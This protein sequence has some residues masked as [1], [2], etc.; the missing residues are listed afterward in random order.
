MT[1][2][3][4]AAAEVRT[5]AERRAYDCAPV[6]G[7][8]RRRSAVVPPTSSRAATAGA[9]SRGRRRTNSFAP[10]RTAF[11]R[12]A[13]AGATHIA[14][15]ARNR[16]E[17]TLPRLRPREG[18]APSA[19]RSTPSARRRTSGTCSPTRRPSGSPARTLTSSPRS[20][21][22]RDEAPAL[23]HVLTFSDLAGLAADGRELARA[24]PDVSGRGVRSHR[25]GRP[26]HDHLHL[27]NDQPPKGCMLRA[28]AT[29]TRW[30]PS[31]TGWRATTART[32]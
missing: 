7:R 18:S 11:S 22:F 2:T 4:S 26:L 16:L 21:L 3:V 32:T 10:T 12:A 9:R 8:G 25:R 19:S 1:E 23:E 24:R 5:S 30:R 17:W 28:T 31:A 14:I 6:A 13:S 29:T 20:T 27:R 15:L